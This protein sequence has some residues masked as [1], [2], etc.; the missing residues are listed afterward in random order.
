[1]G[2]FN[3]LT[4][5]IKPF[6][7]DTMYGS[8]EEMLDA[9]QEPELLDG[10]NKVFCERL[11]E[12]VAAH[13]GLK[14]TQLPYVLTLAF[15]RFDYDLET[16]Q[17]KKINS[18]VRF[19]YVLDMN[20]YCVAPW[21]HTWHGLFSA[22]FKRSAEA[23][24]GVVHRRCRAATGPPSAGTSTA[25]AKVVRRILSFT[26]RQWFEAEGVETQL[27]PPPEP[28]AGGG[29]DQQW[30]G[31]GAS[32]SAA[33]ETGGHGDAVGGAVG[34]AVLLADLPLLVDYFGMPIEEPASKGPK[35]HESAAAPPSLSPCLIGLG[36]GTATG[37]DMS[38]G[39]DTDRIDAAD[40]GYSAS[41]ADMP[42]L[43]RFR[44]KRG[45][46]VYELYSVIIHQGTVTS[47]HY[48]AF[49]KNFE[50]RKWY[51]FNDTSVTQMEAHEVAELSFGG[52]GASQTSSGPALSVAGSGFAAFMSR[53]TWPSTV[54]AATAGSGQRASHP[55]SP[56][57]SEKGGA[58]LGRGA[59]AHQHARPQHP[60]FGN[61]SIATTCS[62]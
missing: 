22:A 26:H 19:P 4:L 17:R 6:G 25:S 16:N 9:Y 3:D 41:D 43:S 33:E 53:S 34:D 14:M 54:D 27:S 47:G 36:K 5:V 38:E 48:Y 21:N 62:L 42:L 7:S 39:T 45:P 8:V 56:S 51:K 52:P 57:S 12:K 23:T 46:Y 2:T 13:K 15:K 61:A 58:S 1:M 40:F 11:K 55:S 35:R 50:D 44:Q 31:T 20:S 18:E 49:I 59:A 10:D 29:E 32:K 24:A 30:A 60:G 28:A 37:G